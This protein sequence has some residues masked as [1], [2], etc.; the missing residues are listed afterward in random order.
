MHL[1]WTHQIAKALV[2]GRPTPALELHLDELLIWLSNP[3]NPRVAELERAIERRLTRDQASASAYRLLDQQF[4]ADENPPTPASLGFA[5][6]TTLTQA[7]QRYRRLMQVYHPDRHPKRAA[8]ATRRTEQINRAFTAFQRGES[9]AVRPGNRKGQ[10]RRT[11][12]RPSYRRLPP[13]W[14]PPALRDRIAPAW[15]W[16]HDRWIGRTPIQRRLSI[17]AAM[18]CVLILTVALWPEKP[19]RPVPR[20]VHHPSGIEPPT[21]LADRPTPRPKPQ[22]PAIA[23]TAPTP[24]AKAAPQPSII[25]TMRAPADSPSGAPQQDTAPPNLEL[26][27]TP[28][29]VDGKRQIQIAPA[30]QPEPQTVATT[31][32]NLGALPPPATTPPAETSAARRP[33]RMTPLAPWADI[34]PAAPPAP[35]TP[36][37]PPLAQGPVSAVR[38]GDTALADDCRNAPEILTRFQHAYQAGALDPLMA[39]Y[40]PLAKENELATWFA[41]RQTYAEWFRITASRRIDFEQIQVQPIADSQRCA[42]MAVFQVS[43]LDQESRS[44]TLAGIIELLL[45]RK[46]SNWLILRARY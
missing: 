24:E 7:K 4:F 12:A 25:P 5:P 42:L 20:I 23:T 40:S 9:G 17:A 46:D 14:L 30:P 33:D 13:T 26:G 34:P 38:S 22:P 21:R 1:S 29:S 41:I 10:T 35:P 31:P 11:A 27:G 3:D 2:S 39:L 18:A 37:T 45:E 6:G 15:I 44:V 8:W 16:I 43:Y 28:E 19:P 32:G 36:P